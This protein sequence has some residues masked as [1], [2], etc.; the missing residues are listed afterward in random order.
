MKKS[1]IYSLAATFITAALALGSLTACSNEDIVAEETLDG[2]TAKSP[3]VYSVNIPA[4]LG[5]D[6]TTRAVTEKDY[7]TEGKKMLESTFRTTDDISVYV[8]IKDYWALKK[9]NDDVYLHADA[10]AKTANLTGELTFWHWADDYY[11]VETGDKLL[12]MY[13]TPDGSFFYKIHREKSDGTYGQKGTLAGLSDYDYAT[14]EVTITNI[15][16]SGTADSPYTLTTTPASFT[17]VQSM[18]KLTFTGMPDNFSYGDGDYGINKITIHSEKGKLAY[19]YDPTEDDYECDD[20]V[21]YLGGDHGDA[22]TARE[23]NGAGNVVYAALHFLP[24]GES[25]TDEITFTIETTEKDENDENI[26]YIAK[27]TSPVGGFQNGKYYTSTIEAYPKNVNLASINADFT[28]RDGQVLTGALD[29]DYQISIADG[30]TVTLDGAD[31]TCLGIGAK[32]AGI[33]CL[34]DA[35]ILLSGTNYL[36]GGLDDNSGVDGLG[37]WPGIFVP[38]GKTLTIDGT[39][40]L[41]ARSGG[42]SEND[43]VAPGIGGVADDAYRGEACGN[44]VIKGGTITAI[45]GGASAGIG[46]AYNYDCGYITITG[47]ASVTAT[48]GNQGGA[49][50]GGGFASVC[51]DITISTTGTVEATG[52]GAGIGA[53]FAEYGTSQCGDITIEGSGTVK[54]KGLD[55]SAGIG[56]GGANNGT[57]ECGDITINGSGTIIATGGHGAAGI[58]AGCAYSGL[59]SSNRCGNILISGGNVTATGGDMAAGIGSGYPGSGCNVQ[60]GTITIKNTVTSVTAT[61]GEN[62]DNSIGRG[63]N[64]TRSICGTVSIGGTVYWGLQDGSSTAYEY[65]NGGN[66]YLKQN[67]LTYEP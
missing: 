31:I 63:R 32:Y 34:G 54:A 27:K 58:G 65:K 5:D 55:F 25:E 22:S 28:A 2:A 15:S 19:Y 11:E 8:K 37:E 23:A 62:A 53:G 17:N 51:G 3:V 43:K 60:C 56:A 7:G 49:G 16:G 36:K 40:S 33:T 29:G 38:A 66:T 59:N 10:N 35:T 57:N 13:N 39:G 42:N 14:A 9:G 45:G 26:I 30:A 24:L 50:I 46:G 47:S 61:K 52:S 41:D 1:Y 64:G 20:L 18:F 12:L 67:T 4:T 48:G 44:I 21:I 6:G